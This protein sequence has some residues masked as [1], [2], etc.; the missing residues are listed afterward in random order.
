[1]LPVQVRHDELEFA[2]L[3]PIGGTFPR[4]QNVL[5]EQR[6]ERAYSAV[7][8]RNGDVEIALPVLTAALEQHA[9]GEVVV[10]QVASDARTDFEI[11]GS[12]SGEVHADALRVGVG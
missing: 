5:A 1:M 9:G 3:R 4:I 8:A 7:W 2:S 10:V 6:R 11:I 12:E